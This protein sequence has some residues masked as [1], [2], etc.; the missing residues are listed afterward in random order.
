HAILAQL[1]YLAWLIDRAG[2]FGGA[3]YAFLFR[4]KPTGVAR[5]HIDEAPAWREPL[6]VHVPITTNDEAFL[7]SQARAKHFAVGEAWTFDNQAIHAAVN[8][9]T[10]RTHMILDVPRNPT[11]EALLEA[12]T[13]DPGVVDVPRWLKASLPNRPPIR[14]FADAVPLT[15][16]EKQE[17]GLPMDGFAARI[18]E[19]F[20][21]GTC[22]GVGD[23]VV[24][25]DGVCECPV[26][27]TA[28][29]YVSLSCAP[30]QTIR[31]EL[32]RGGA[33]LTADLALRGES[34]AGEATNRAP[35]P[36]R[37]V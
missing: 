2:P 21:A 17:V 16:V 22:L 7:L 10:V 34:S 3:T 14:Q 36:G 30:G 4:M 24:S 32:I 1:P 37:M 12:A 13:W 31:L 27:R 9:P 19:L 26:A 8:G 15:M 5:P 11:M 25:V 6:R 35:P 23:I 20:E 33:R 18:R 28:L 29:D